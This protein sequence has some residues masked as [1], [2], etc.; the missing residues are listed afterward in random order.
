MTYAALHFRDLALNALLARDGTPSDHPAALLSSGHAGE[1]EKSHLIA[2]NSSARQL[3]IHPGLRTIR[4]LARC[5][6]LLL[7]DPDPSSEQSAQEET[8]A[9]V[10]SLVP[11]F[12]PTT[13]ETY[14]LDLSTLLIPSNDDWIADT[15]RASR[16]LALPLQIG[17]GPTPDLAHLSSLA[18]GQSDP[19]ALPLNELIRTPAFPIPHARVLQLWGLKTLGDLAQL[20]R[21]GLAE[22]L[23]PDLARLHDILHQ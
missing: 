17:L 15:L 2:V 10:D 3:N 19:H 18:P 1:R 13:P 5:P 22:R 9:F 20:P 8:L 11:D 14:L 4:G 23:G 7:L 12:E 16:S 6:D 21:Q